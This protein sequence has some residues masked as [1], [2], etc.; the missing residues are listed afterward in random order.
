RVKLVSEAGEYVGRAVLVPL[1]LR[2]IQL[3]WPEG[4]V[5]LTR[6]YDPISCEPNYK[7]FATVTKA[8]ETGT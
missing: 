4:N 8:P 6:C 3:H 7:A 2:T 1:R 5:L